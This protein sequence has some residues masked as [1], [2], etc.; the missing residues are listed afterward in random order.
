MTARATEVGWLVEGTPGG[1]GI[2]RPSLCGKSRS[3]PH[4]LAYVRVAAAP[5]Y[6]GQAG[7]R[8][9]AGLL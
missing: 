4:S 2:H 1:L 6:D 8:G 9:V 5:G 3:I 7:I